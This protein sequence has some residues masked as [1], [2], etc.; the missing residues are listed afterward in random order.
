MQCGAVLCSVV[1]CDALWC[2]V[3]CAVLCGAVWC[4]LVQCGEVWFCVVQCGKTLWSGVGSGVG[5]YNESVVGGRVLVSSAGKRAELGKAKTGTTG[6]FLES[7]GHFD[8]KHMLFC[9]GLFC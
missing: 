9:G 5:S 3:C 7:L 6:S 8:E 2:C 4:F 1:Q